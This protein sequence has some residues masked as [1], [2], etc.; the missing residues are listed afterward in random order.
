M[1]C[2][3]ERSCSQQQSQQEG[4]RSWSMH[5]WT[6]MRSVMAEK[7]RKADAHSPKRWA[8]RPTPTSR[9]LVMMWWLQNFQR[10]RRRSQQQQLLAG[11][12]KYGQTRRS[13]DRCLS[14]RKQKI[15]HA[16]SSWV[17]A[18]KAMA[19]EI[20]RWGLRSWRRRSQR[21]VEEHTA[22]DHTKLEVYREKS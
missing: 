6:K 3:R 20:I 13:I 15:G 5:A 10:Y 22:V 17:A 18:W 1:L 7:V 9:R 14:R 4:M 2:R 16:T 19:A 11:Q 12:A 21:K 8:T